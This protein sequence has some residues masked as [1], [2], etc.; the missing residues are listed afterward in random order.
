MQQSANA[1]SCKGRQNFIHRIVQGLN[2]LLTSAQDTNLIVV[3]PTD[4]PE[5]TIHNAALHIVTRILVELPS[6]SNSALY[7]LHFCDIT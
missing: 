4:T 1:S 2:V 3:T 7:V 5:P 6:F